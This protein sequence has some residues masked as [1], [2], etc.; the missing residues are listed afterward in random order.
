MYLISSALNGLYYYYPLNLSFNGINRV[1]K[2]SVHLNKL[3][4]FYITI[5]ELQND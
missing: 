2:V 4:T 1:H 3:I 5:Y